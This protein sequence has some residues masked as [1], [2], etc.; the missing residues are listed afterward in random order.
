MTLDLGTQPMANSFLANEDDEELTFPLKL[1]LC[2]DCFHL[3]LSHAVDPDLLFRN[4][5][6]VSGTSQTLKDYF[7]W[8]AEFASGQCS[9]EPKTVLDIACND[10]TQLDAFKAK[11]LVTYGIDPA[12]NLHLISSKNHNVICDYFTKT[13]VEYYKNQHIDIINAQNVF[14]HN[15]Y[16]LDFLK[17]CREIMHDDSV[18]FIQT[19]QADMV[20]NNEFDTIYHEHLSFFCANSMN[21][22]ARRADLHLLD[23]KKTPIHGNSY[24]FVFTKTPKVSVG[25]EEFLRDE[26]DAG[27]NTPATYIEYAKKA[28][29]AVI[30]LKNAISAYRAEGYVIA[31]YGAA[32]KGMTLLNFGN[33]QLDFIIDDNP[34]KQGRFTPG[35]HIPVV[36]IDM[37]DECKDLNVAF[38]PLAWNFF[39]EIKTKIKTKRDC[40]E[41]AFIRYFPTISIE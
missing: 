41:D 1:N 25:V 37:L 20:R 17:Q 30:D 7:A 36:A 8:F 35:M 10:G 4:Y 24:V 16:P 31:G 14:A 26:R 5:L 28:K 39:D 12:T 2:R 33:I 15:D 32:A 6:Y 40:K 38:V 29:Q 23:I 27:L 21:E 9:F 3:Q 13:H 34:L 19:S 18:L 22:L 11:G